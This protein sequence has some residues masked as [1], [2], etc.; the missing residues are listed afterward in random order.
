[1]KHRQRRDQVY[2]A[3]AEIERLRAECERLKLLSACPMCGR[4]TCEGTHEKGT[5]ARM[6]ILL[7][8]AEVAEAKL[9]EGYE[10]GMGAL[11]SCEAALAAERAKTAAETARAERCIKIA[12]DVEDECYEDLGDKAGPK[13]GETWKHLFDRAEMAEARTAKLVEALE[14]LMRKGLTGD[15]Y[16]KAEAALSVGPKTTTNAAKASE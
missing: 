5:A 2:A 14:Y 7:D 12:Q 10:R 6:Q 4:E 9:A 1:M 16:A 11:R 8:R 15:G 13:H 3:Q